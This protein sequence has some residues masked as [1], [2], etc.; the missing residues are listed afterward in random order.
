M[1]AFISRVCA[2][3]KTSFS[4]ASIR[5]RT[6]IELSV[7]GGMEGC[8]SIRRS[9]SSRLNRY[10]SSI[11]KRIRFL[12]ADTLRLAPAAIREERHSGCEEASRSAVIPP[13]L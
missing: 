4:P 7:R 11:R 1:E 5:E 9:F 13:S 2:K 10:S 3:G 8:F 6:V 12:K